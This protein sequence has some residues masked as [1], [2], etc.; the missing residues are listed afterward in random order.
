MY[1]PVLSVARDARGSEIEATDRTR[2]LGDR[3]AES[4]YRSVSGGRR[5]VERG[6]LPGRLSNGGSPS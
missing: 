1:G 5:A 4:D 2:K 3:T 6:A